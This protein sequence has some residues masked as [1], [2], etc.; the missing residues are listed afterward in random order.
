MHHV[1][2]YRISIIDDSNTIFRGVTRDIFHRRNE[3]LKLA[4]HGGIY[5]LCE[6]FDIGAVQSSHR[7]AS[8]AG[9]VH[10]CLFGKGLGL[11]RCKTGETISILVRREIK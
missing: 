8:V 7:N 10:M 3:I 4:P 2:E 1:P 5:A 9:H 11:G 6:V